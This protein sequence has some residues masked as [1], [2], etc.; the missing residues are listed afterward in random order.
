MA[1]SSLDS[2]SIGTYVISFR[3]RFRK[4]LIF[5]GA[6]LP[7]FRSPNPATG[8]FTWNSF[9]ALRRDSSRKFTALVV[10]AVT[11]RKVWEDTLTG[12]T[13]VEAGKHTP[14]RVDLKLKSPLSIPGRRLFP[15]FPARC[16]FSLSY[17]SAGI[18]VRPVVYACNIETSTSSLPC[19][20][21]DRSS[22]SVPR[23]INNISRILYF[24]ND[25]I[26]YI[27][28]YKILSLF[29]SRQ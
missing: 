5:Q 8:I 23:E 24:F 4:S 12:E 7:T 27:L 21:R 17:P 3:P 25:Y 11:Q 29:Y 18:N 22:F 1:R 26:I 13:G 2:A 6:F 9:A 10:R 14:C 20:L 15:E 19:I 28:L 16:R